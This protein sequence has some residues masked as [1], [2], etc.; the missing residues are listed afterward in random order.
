MLDIAALFPDQRIRRFQAGYAADN[1]HQELVKVLPLG[2]KC[3]R[4]NGLLYSNGCLVI[5]KEPEICLMIIHTDHESLDHPGW[6]ETVS[7]L[8]YPA[9]DPHATFRTAPAPTNSPLFSPHSSK[10]TLPLPTQPSPSRTPNPSFS[11]P[12]L[13]SQRLPQQPDA[14]S[15]VSTSSPSPSNLAFIQSQTWTLLP[16]L[17]FNLPTNL[18]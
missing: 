12:M 7:R 18:S 10:L 4:I 13:S 1:F 3:T 15:P 2:D 11:G 9:Q 16:Q 8:A 14:S 6:I 17:K 5:P